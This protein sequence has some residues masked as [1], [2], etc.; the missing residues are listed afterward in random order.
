MCL[1]QGS[2]RVYQPYAGVL[3]SWKHFKCT[4]CLHLL[5]GFL[6][7]IW[8]LSH[9]LHFRKRRK[10]FPKIT[11]KC[12]VQ[13]WNFQF[14]QSQKEG[15][16]GSGG[17]GW[18]GQPVNRKLIPANWL[19]RVNNFGLRYSWANS[20]TIS[21]A[22]LCSFV[23]WRGYSLSHDAYLQY[24]YFWTFGICWIRKLENYHV[25]Y[26]VCRIPSMMIYFT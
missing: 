22:P 17:E 25:Q 1:L 11:P 14:L 6:N 9:Y 24:Q 3:N 8:N 5:S 12:C 7:L 23:L 18:W 4:G 16:G 20:L 2:C 26:C 21:V 10:T 15:R 13:K 19:W